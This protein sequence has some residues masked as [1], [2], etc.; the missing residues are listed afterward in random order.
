[1]GSVFGRIEKLKG[2]ENEYKSGQC[3]KRYLVCTKEK[4]RGT[5]QGHSTS[6]EDVKTVVAM[7]T[8]E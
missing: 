1:M 7:Q 4:E 3:Q 2:K 8:K 5:P 6:K